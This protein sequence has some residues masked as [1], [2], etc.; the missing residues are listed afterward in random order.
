M[1]RQCR[2]P[3]GRHRV[4]LER[5]KDKN[6]SEYKE[7]VKGQ[8]KSHFKL[9]LCLDICTGSVLSVPSIVWVIVYLLPS[10]TPLQSKMYTCVHKLARLLVTH[11]MYTCT[12]PYNTCVT[13][14]RD[15]A[16]KASWALRSL[17]LSLDKS[18]I[19][20][21]MYTESNECWG[22]LQPQVL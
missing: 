19:E 8:N 6:R 9:V 10:K 11:H 3:R 16:T 2:H 14:Y 18:Q 1:D 12:H 21:P 20:L 13:G 4:R 5:S 17:T 7:K 22:T 15:T